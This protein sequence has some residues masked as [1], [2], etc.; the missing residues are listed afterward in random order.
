M[1]PVTPLVPSVQLR[2][3]LTEDARDGLDDMLSALA[4]DPAGLGRCFPSAARRIGRGEVGD[5]GRRIEDAVRVELVFAAAPRLSPSAL[6]DELGELYRYGDSDERRAV[7]LALSALDDPR[8]DGSTMLLDALRTNDARLVAAAMGPHADR[9][10]GHDWRHGVLKCLFMGI[11][12][13]SVADLPRR[14]DTELV[15]MVRRY[16]AERTAAG[17]L[18]PEDARRVLHMMSTDPGREA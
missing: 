3:A 1:T 13:A 2:A 11:P 18:I 6:L 16:V 17:R 15:E 12:L 9:L 5:T 7:L 14:V 8:L 10:P 4:A